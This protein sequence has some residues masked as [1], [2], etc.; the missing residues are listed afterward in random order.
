MTCRRSFL[1]WVLVS[2]AA[3]LAGHAFA[4]SAL[5]LRGTIEEEGAAAP[6]TS[7]LADTTLEVSPPDPEKEPPERR[8][9]AISDPYAPA[10]LGND[11]LKLYPSITVGSVYSS[12]ARQ[13]S[14]NRRGDAGLLLKPDLQLKSAWSR[15]ALTAGLEGSMVRFAGQSDFD[16]ATL[17]LF[18]RLRLDVRRHTTADINSSYALDEL[19]GTDATE[20]SLSGS[21]AVTQDFGPMSARIAAGSNVRLFEDVKLGKGVVEDNSDRDYVEP[22]LALRTI[23]NEYGVIKP[24]VE[25][26]YAPRIHTRATD[27][28]GIGRDSTGYG[29][30]AGVQ[31]DTGPIWAGDLGLTYLHRNYDAVSLGS[32][33]AFGLTGSLTWSPTELTKIVMASGTSL[34]ETTEAGTPANTIWRA[35]L[36]MTYALRDNVDLS[37]GAAVEIEDTGPSIDK[38]YDGK[39]EVEWKFNPVL[40]WSA[41]YDLTWLDSATADDG[42]VEHRV[43]TGLTISR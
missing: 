15:H 25:A 21:L 30:T 1:A 20:H 23:Y 40:S 27:R 12:N 36:D 4:Q 24:Y 38:T 18:E 6:T 5:P 28:N 9:K 22:S 33:E 29:I 26:S 32:A 37:A 3:G 34:D 13:S 39:L 43:S 2:L 10:G 17:D 14:N 35:S 7:K 16:T 11:A 31:L 41:G 19:G 8:A 42:Y